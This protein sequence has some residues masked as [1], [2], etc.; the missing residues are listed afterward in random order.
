M[1]I[2]VGFRNALIVGLVR[3]MWVCSFWICIIQFPEAKFSTLSEANS[4][5]RS[6]WN[7]QSDQH[8][9]SSCILFR[10]KQGMLMNDERSSWYKEI[11]KCRF[12]IWG[13]K[14]CTSMDQYMRGHLKQPHSKVWGQWHW[15]LWQLIV[16]DLFIYLWMGT[17]SRLL[18]L[19]PRRY[20]SSVLFKPHNAKICWHAKSTIKLFHLTAATLCPSLYTL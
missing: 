16:S 2:G 18:I 6:L 5:F 11:F 13:K 20:V 17:W 12:R 10:W 14:F 7:F 8:F 4:Y 1:L 3:S 9:G 15:V 19:C